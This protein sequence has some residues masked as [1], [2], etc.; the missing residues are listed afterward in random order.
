MLGIFALLFCSI[1]A[2]A[3][4]EVR[5]LLSSRPFGPDVSHFQGTV[6]WAKVR[7]TGAGF[8]IAKATEGTTYA[9]AAFKANWAGMKAAGIPVRG[10]YHFGHPESSATTQAKHFMSVVGTTVPGDFVA[11]DIESADSQSASAVASW[12]AAFV[13]EV[14]S[15]S[16]LPKS[17]IFIYTGAWFWNPQAGGS[18][19]V[20]DHPLWVSGYTTSPPMPSGWSHWTM[21]QYS[22][23]ET[24]Y[25]INS[26]CDSSYY[27]GSQTELEALVGLG[28]SPSPTPPP[29]PTPTPSSCSEG[30]CKHNSP[31]NACGC[32]RSRESDCGHTESGSPYYC[33]GS[34]DSTCPKMFNSTLV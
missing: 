29:A 20:G 15:I 12:C 27:Q 25:G 26:G 24:K 5:S 4:S 32:C 7:A 2:V 31:A 23:T 30:Y 18:S 14:K 34:R 33:Q 17:R 6:D 10:A 19:V 3:D 16:G 13:N 9:D 21:W 1:V 11:L 28:P 22:S 8:A